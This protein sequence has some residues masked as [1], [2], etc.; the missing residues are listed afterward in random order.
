MLCTALHVA[1]DS[2]T[3]RPPHGQLLD[4]RTVDEET[5]AEES[6]DG[7]GV[8]PNQPPALEE[9]V[10]RAGLTP[11]AADTRQRLTRWLQDTADDHLACALDSKRG[12]PAA[13]FH[14]VL[15]ARADGTEEA[16]EALERQRAKLKRFKALNRE[17]GDELRRDHPDDRLKLETDGVHRIL[18]M[19]KTR[20]IFAD[21]DPE[22]FEQ[23]TITSAFDLH[24]CEVHRSLAAACKPWIESQGASRPAGPASSVLP[25]F[26]RLSETPS[27]P[28][29]SPV[30]PQTHS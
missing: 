30:L 13:A 2:R 5:P 23:E 16:F 20:R 29:S 26:R 17:I 10:D 7:D 19:V 11:L 27:R 14:A 15:A 6:P 21:V 28:A 25:R 1:W 8:K 24:S 12:Y 22:S 18:D 3:A 9:L 4:L